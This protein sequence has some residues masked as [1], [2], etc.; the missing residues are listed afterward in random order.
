MVVFEIRADIYFCDACRRLVHSAGIPRGT[1]TPVASS[2]AGAWYL[3][4]ELHGEAFQVEA[5]GSERAH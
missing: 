2:L 3:G 4:L 5:S 1:L